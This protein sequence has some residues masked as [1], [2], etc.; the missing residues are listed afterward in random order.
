MPEHSKNEEAKTVKDIEVPMS[1]ELPKEIEDIKKILKESYKVPVMEVKHEK[2]KE[3]KAREI[4]DE[5][6]LN[7]GKIREAKK[8]PHGHHEVHLR[9]EDEHLRLNKPGHDA[10]LG[11]SNEKRKHEEV[12]PI[13]QDSQTQKEEI[14]D[15]LKIVED[16]E[17]FTGYG[18]RNFPNG[19]RYEG[20]W[21]QGKMEGYGK[22]DFANGDKYE[23][24]YVSGL[25]S[26]AGIY[27]Y[28]N[29]SKYEGQWKDGTRCGKGA[30]CLYP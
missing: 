3:V 9:H 6:I 14:I 8:N 18:V 29:G 27:C 28:S 5:A 23:G 25:I 22:Y 17:E 15:G 20:E 1:Y 30:L 11:Q 13:S 12:P 26:G 16:N 19:D 21:K 7:Y 4:N 2:P 24:E 10:N